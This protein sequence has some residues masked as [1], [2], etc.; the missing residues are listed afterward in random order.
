MDRTPPHSKSP[1]IFVGDSWQGNCRRIVLAELIN[2]G[3]QLADSNSLAEA[4][5][6]EMAD[7]QPLNDAIKR[8]TIRH[9]CVILYTACR[10]DGSLRQR[11][12][13][14]ELWAYLYDKARSRTK[15]ADQRQEYAQLALAKTWENLP[16]INDPGNLLKYALLILFS[17]IRDHNEQTE[18]WTRRED[19][20]SDMEHPDSKQDEIPF[21]SIPD[22]LT[23][24]QFDQIVVDESMRELAAIIRRCI[25]NALQQRVVIELFLNDKD[26]V[27][28]AEEL[29]L[30]VNYIDQLRHRALQALEKC[31][32]YRRSVEDKL[33]MREKARRHSPKSGAANG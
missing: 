29:A 8:A 3:W 24:K 28:V 16:Q 17:K 15:N 27:E 20:E 11:R 13:F 5:C 26:R 33:K 14:Q 21:E 6:R 10:D 25:E 4:I 31:D 12:A 18:T 30:Q 23:G 2:R 9:Y 22:D 7:S 1:E 32:A 19:T